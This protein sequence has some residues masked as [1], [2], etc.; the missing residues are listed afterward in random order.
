MKIGARVMLL[1][2]AVSAC[3]DDGTGPGGGPPPGDRLE[4]A[5]GALASTAIPRLAY[6]PRLEDYSNDHPQ[7]R[8]LRLSR[9]V[10][11]LVLRPQVTVGEANALLGTLGAEIV[12]GIP[13]TESLSGILALRLPTQTH[14]DMASALTM[15]RQDARV[16]HAVQE[17]LVDPLAVP[18]ADPTLPSWSWDLEPNGG[19]WGL[20]ISRVPQLW[21]LNAAVRKAGNTTLVTGVLDGGFTAHNDVGFLNSP[22][23][24]SESGH[25]TTV[26]GIIAAR[27]DSTGVDGVN[28]FAHLRGAITQTAVWDLY[29][30]L[31]AHPEMDVINISMGAEWDGNDL[32]TDIAAQQLAN[33][34]GATLRHALALVEAQLG[35]LPVIVTAAGNESNT[36]VGTQPA[37]YLSDFNNAGLVQGAANIIVVEALDLESGVATRRLSSNIGGHVSAPG[38][39]ILSTIPTNTY[40]FEDGTSMAAP[41]VAGLAGYLYALDPTLPRAGRVP[42]WT[43]SQ[44]RWRSTALTGTT[45]CCGCSPTWMTAQR[46]VT[47]E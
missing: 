27:H 16:A 18:A 17:R 47:R 40:G 23:V 14:A 43:R 13:G 36:A 20:E 32:N 4:G 15:L 41:H 39:G 34:G 24:G 21:N 35:S 38:G 44:P 9:R 7:L 6:E 5:S 8:G 42:A 11:N 30:F 3:R 29:A 33:E 28:P 2:L 45:A 25:G 19:N 26:A 37:S 46:T 22:P 12:G 10:L 1:L 31:I